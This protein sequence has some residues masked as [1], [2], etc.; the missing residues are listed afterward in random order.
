MSTIVDKFIRLLRAGRGCCSDHNSFGSRGDNAEY[1]AARIARDNPEV[2]EGMK[3][4]RSA[5]PSAALFDGGVA[6]YI[7]RPSASHGALVKSC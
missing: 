6:G 7:R 1:L 5:N 3:R 4:G 2:L